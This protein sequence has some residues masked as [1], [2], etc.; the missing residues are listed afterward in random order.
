[1]DKTIRPARVSG[2]VRIPGSKSHSIRALVIA[3]L[4]EG[5]S[6][7]IDPLISSDTR[8]CLNACKAFGAKI[9][10]GD[11]RWTVKGTGGKLQTPENIIDVDN[12]GTT[13]YLLTAVAALQANY[14][15][16]T[17]DEQIRSRPAAPLL[18]SIRDLGATAYS[19]RNNGK[20]PYV[21]GG[22]LNG[23][24][25]SISCPT[26]QYLS[27]LLLAAPLAAQDTTI[28]IP[29]LHER[30]YVEMTLNWLDA[31][32][33]R[34]TNEDFARMHLPG[35]RRYSA[36][37]R[38]IPGDFSSAT[39]FMCAAA[40]CGSTLTVE[41]LDFDDPQGDKSVVD[42]L[43]AL[44]CTAEKTATGV[45]ISGG[46]LRGCDLDLNATPDALPALAVT[47]CFADRITRLMNVP[48]AREKETDRITVMREE[49]TKMGAELEEMPDGLIIHGHGKD[50]RPVLT[51]TRVNGRGDHRV[52]MALAVAAL[53][54]AGET[55][56]EGAEAADVTFPQFFELLESV[57]KGE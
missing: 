15:V 55:V 21:I 52:V 28:E 42:M 24:N 8:A 33:I 30:P 23:G 26:S 37:T 54:A 48:Q 9:A 38:R 35:G 13:L 47:A 16:F 29:L 20:P 57:T 45:T 5:E 27:S 25:T 39:F 6:E 36:F 18:Q 49:L 14:V 51:G 43:G 50:R 3:T 53:A 10:E 40:I 12:S 2:T 4:A 22:T 56:I 7:I 1:M 32:G 19:A 46:D 34:Y 31:Q 44:G 41:G 17:G 11:G